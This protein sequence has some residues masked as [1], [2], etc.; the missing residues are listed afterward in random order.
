MSASASRLAWLAALCALTIITHKVAANATRDGLFFSS[1]ESS[2]L[3]K[4]MLIS[5]ALALATVALTSKV[6]ARWGP[7]LVIPVAF[8]VNAALYLIEWTFLD[9]SPA[10]VSAA[11]YAQVASIGAVL[12]SGF[13]SAVNERFDPVM[14][15]KAIGRI[16]SGA[17][18]GGVLGGLLAERVSSWLGAKT[19]LLFLAGLCVVAGAM[20]FALR[21][22]QVRGVSLGAE[23]HTGKTKISESQSSGWSVLRNNSYLRDLGILV[24]LAAVWAALLDYAFKTEAARVYTSRESLTQFF[25]IF[26]TGAG[27]VTLLAQ[28]LLTRRAL[29]RFG[30]AGTVSTVPLMV[31]IFGALSLAGRFVMIVI[32]RAVESALANSLYR[33]G[34]ELFFIPLAASD[35]RAT[36]TILD[37]AFNRLGDAV[38]A[39]LILLITWLFAAGTGFDWMRGIADTRAAVGVAI[40]IGICAL[41]LSI[42][43]H[44]GYVRTLQ[45]NLRSGVVSLRLGD[46]DLDAT[47]KRTLSD[48]TA[49]LDRDQLLNEI[50]LWREGRVTLAP[51]LVAAPSQT[52]AQPPAQPPAQTIEAETS[53]LRQSV[54]FTLNDIPD[55]TYFAKIC[56][57]LQKSDEA[58]AV[59]NERPL[60]RRMAPFVIP[61][62]AEAKFAQAAIEALKSSAENNAGLL[63]DALFD[64]QEEMIVRR[65][66]PRILKDVSRSSTALG[67]LEAQGDHSFE[68]RYYS[69]VALNALGVHNDPKRGT[70][71]H[72]PFS[73]DLVFDRVTKELDSDWSESGTPSQRPKASNAP[74]DILVDEAMDD[75][76]SRSTKQLAHV[77][78]LLELVVVDPEGIQTALKAVR[79]RDQ[80]LVATSSEY[81]LTVL[82]EKI[83][84]K[85]IQKIDRA[86]KAS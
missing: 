55:P 26:Y 36:K 53:G 50:K 62:L 86:T 51:A 18:I 73:S 9:V 34:Y 70:G 77:F 3:P 31:A 11:L 43:L 60:T 76:V 32:T 72:V 24:L 1:H 10:W 61:L 6:L 56:A 54:S 64:P 37:V 17:T 81:L 71:L 42:R 67:L 12:I 13:W 57:L 69:A 20:V 40:V 30:L 52:S 28:T 23:G 84:R 7:Y 82:P 4:M 63:L 33:A 41:L 49:L 44:N 2:S 16:G 66:I 65:R 74:Q 21:P 38:G 15:K 75:Q 19:M 79:S 14:A 47:T 25:G 8:L 5:S 78:H 22:S 80:S 48:T 59:L 27:V 29:E 45:T 68:I 35:K 46:L 83:A 85:L 58:F 39:G